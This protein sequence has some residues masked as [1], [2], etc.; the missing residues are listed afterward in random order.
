MTQDEILAAK[1]AALATAKSELETA[2]GFRAPLAPG[3]R[4]SY[5]T[6][7]PSITA[8][9]TVGIRADAADVLRAAAG[10]N[11]Q[12]PDGHL[13]R[14]HAPYGGAVRRSSRHQG[15]QAAQQ[16]QQQACLFFLCNGSGLP[17]PSRVGKPPKSS[18]VG[19]GWVALL[20]VKTH[21][22]VQGGFENRARGHFRT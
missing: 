16:R 22:Y 4:R 17:F 13:R 1:A 12:A 10:G 2:A 14:Y 15:T 6:D 18:S 21:C 7:R 8:R 20:L 5:G 9:R 19:T 3:L 11:E